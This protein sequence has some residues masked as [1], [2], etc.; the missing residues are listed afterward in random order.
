MADDLAA[1]R[2][3]IHGVRQ[4]DTVI[5]AMRGIAAA[6]AQ[7]SRLLLPGF[8][9]YAEVIAGR[10]PRRCGSATTR[11]P[12][13]VGPRRDARASCSAPSR[14]LSVALPSEFWMTP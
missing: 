4:L 10:S 8:R 13:A 1:V 12:A 7:Q 11:R 6:H 14:D 3:R 2:T 9:A 5:G